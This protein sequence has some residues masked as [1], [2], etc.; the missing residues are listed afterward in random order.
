M[1]FPEKSWNFMTSL[2]KDKTFVNKAYA[3]Q[4]ANWQVYCVDGGLNPTYN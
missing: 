2:K 4:V 3:K 1:M